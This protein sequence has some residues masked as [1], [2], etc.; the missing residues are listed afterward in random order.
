[1]RSLVYVHDVTRMPPPSMTSSLPENCHSAIIFTFLSKH[2]SAFTDTSE[3]IGFY[4]CSDIW[5]TFFNIEIVC[6]WKPMWSFKGPCKVK[7]ILDIHF[8]FSI[9]IYF[10]VLVF[11]FYIFY[12]KW[13][14][15]HQPTHPLPLFNV[16]NFFNFATS[17]RTTVWDVSPIS[18]IWWW[19]GAEGTNDTVRINTLTQGGREHLII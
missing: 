11:H 19:G 5:L 4:L 15:T 12:P 3:N 8:S 18:V 9:F 2:I 10:L 13:P 7:K 16:W 6:V 1:M 17:L 14:W